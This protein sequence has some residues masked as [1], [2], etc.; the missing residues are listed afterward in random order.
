MGR[1]NGLDDVQQSISARVWRSLCMGINEETQK[2]LGS[3]TTW[4]EWRVLV[5]I[6][7]EDGKTPDQ[8]WLITRR[9]AF[10]LLVRSKIKEICDQLKIKKPRTKALT[11]FKLEEIAEKWLDTIDREQ[12]WEGALNFLASKDSM[13]ADQLEALI[14]EWLGKSPQSGKARSPSTIYRA[15]ARSG[16]RFSRKKTYTPNQVQ[17]IFRRV[18]RNSPK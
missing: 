17:K 3:Q 6:V 16:V 2:P 15:C 13:T 9:E 10:L 14:Q 12:S 5:G 18:Q 7:T 1:I 8:R 11:I 4:A